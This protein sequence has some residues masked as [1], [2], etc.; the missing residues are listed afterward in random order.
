M[1][2][3]IPTLEKRRIRGDLIQI[4]K[5]F[6]VLEEVNLCNY[7]SFNSELSTRGHSK[8]YT[9]ELCKYEQRQIFLMNRAANKWNELPMEVIESETVNEFKIKLDNYM[10]EF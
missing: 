2:M 1:K 6:N 8:R 3:G 7:P 10:S 5:I 9:R 4:F